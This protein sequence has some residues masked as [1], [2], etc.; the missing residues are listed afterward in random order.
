MPTDVPDEQGLVA[1]YVFD[2]V[3]MTTVQLDT[4]FNS[5]MKRVSELKAGKEA[6]ILSQME[7]N[8][9]AIMESSMQETDDEMSSLA[10]N[11]YRD[12]VSGSYSHF[13][14]EPAAKRQRVLAES[15][16]IIESKDAAHLGTCVQHGFSSYFRAKQAG[17]LDVVRTDVLEA[18]LGDIRLTMEDMRDQA[19]DP[20]SDLDTVS[21]YTAGTQESEPE[22][23]TM[24]RRGKTSKKRLQ[25]PQGLKLPPRSQ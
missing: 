11:S 6:G 18:R 21:S 4:C 13:L 24:D 5:L 2:G 12:R 16:S 20:F 15:F 23:Q 10:Y 9:L 7:E 3:P 25:C 14:T 8:V 1:E 19:S 17:V 22:W